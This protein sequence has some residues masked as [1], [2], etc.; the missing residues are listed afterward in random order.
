[1]GT[2]VTF[3]DGRPDRSLYRRYRIRTVKGSD[4]YAMIREVV[5][6][7]LGRIVKDGAEV[8]DLLVIDGG[9]GQLSAAVE[10]A[11]ASGLRGIALV[12]L[13]KREEEVFVP[14]R[15]TPV[16][17]PEDGRP[18]KLLQ[19][20]RNEVHRFSIAYHRRLREKNARRSLL[21]DVPGVGEARKEA[22]LERFGSVA[23]IG[24]RTVEELTEVPGI[25]AETAK[26]IKETL[27]G[28]GRGDR[29]ERGGP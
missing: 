14:G 6:R 21:D 25:G 22:L 4:D 9:K 27:D 28:A 29:P 26:K 15:A 17:L 1:V 13:A 8:P 3:R 16:P 11:R 7:H 18:K 20:I 23:A 10:A 2:V 12:S 24:E 5:G 19:R